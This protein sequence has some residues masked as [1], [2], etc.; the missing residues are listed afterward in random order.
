MTI[1]AIISLLI[2]TAIV[3]DFG[4]RVFAYAETGRAE[5]K[6]QHFVWWRKEGE[7]SV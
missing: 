7:H 4:A 1:K 5:Y 3:V 6:H 2:L